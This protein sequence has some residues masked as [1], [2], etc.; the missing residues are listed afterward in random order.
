MP[1]YNYKLWDFGQEPP[2]FMTKD[3]I[4]EDRV[5]DFMVFIVAAP[6]YPSITE[7]WQAAREHIGLLAYEPIGLLAYEPIEG[8]V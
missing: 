2:A 8:V 5:G 6:G 3:L 7:A 4:D 1:S